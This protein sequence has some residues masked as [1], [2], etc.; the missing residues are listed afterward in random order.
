MIKSE[1][2][3][4]IDC[5]R[6]TLMYYKLVVETCDKKSNYAQVMQ[7]ELPV[8]REM[9]ALLPVKIDKMTSRLQ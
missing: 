6:K 4:Q 1:P 5:M 9:A 3:E 2:V 7:A 8:C